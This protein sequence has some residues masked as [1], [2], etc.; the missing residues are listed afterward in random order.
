M[1]L[2]MLDNEHGE[3]EESPLV[4]RSP[5]HDSLINRIQFILSL[6]L[7]LQ[8]TQVANPL[9]SSDCLHYLKTPTNLFK[10]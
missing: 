9:L 7:L 10:A 6:D 2:N 1:M 8:L 5:K 3:Q 4:Y